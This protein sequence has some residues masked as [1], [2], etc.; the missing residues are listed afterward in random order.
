MGILLFC[1]VRDSS[2]LIHSRHIAL[3]EVARVGKNHAGLANLLC[4][5]GQFFE[6]RRYLLFVIGRLSNMIFNNKTT[7]VIYCGLRI[8]SLYK[9]VSRRWHYARLRICQV[10]LIFVPGTRRWGFR[11]FAPWLFFRISDRITTG[12]FFLIFCQFLLIELFSS[13][14]NFCLGIGNHLEAIFPAF[15]LIRNG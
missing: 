15:Q 10:D 3:T 13:S 2:K 11:F 7:V 14:L 12:N 1:N 8:I 4:T 9:T 6:G 5:R